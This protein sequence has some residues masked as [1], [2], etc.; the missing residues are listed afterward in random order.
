[1]NGD[2]GAATLRCPGCGAPAAAGASSCAYCR[3]TLATVSCPSCFGLLF[4]GASFCQHCGAARSRKELGGDDPRTAC[5]ACK[6]AMTWT[7]IGDTDLLECASCQGTWVEAETFERLCSDRASQAA[8]L[9]TWSNPPEQANPLAQPIRYRRCPRCSR[10]MNRINF[11]KISGTVVDVCKG[12]GTFLDRYELHHIVRFIQGGGM[13]RSRAAEREQIVEEQQRLRDLQRVQAGLA[14]PD[15][16]DRFSA[17]ALREF[18]KAL[19]G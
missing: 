18:L 15:H 2:S 5:P 19:L 14:P 1:M 11:G 4:A 17:G 10:M 12:H 7:R 8:L 16:A 6:K 9:H 13:D 3:A